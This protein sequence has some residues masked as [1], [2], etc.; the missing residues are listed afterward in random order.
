[1]KVLI[2]NLY[3]LK[4]D[5]NIVQIRK[6]T[7]ESNYDMFPFSFKHILYG[8]RTDF[9]RYLG[10]EIY[11]TRKPKHEND[12]VYNVTTGDNICGWQ[13]EEIIEE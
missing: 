9:S 1:M 10:C 5:P 11:L 3:S 6:R 2:R 13:V 7:D 12:I 4:N 8:T